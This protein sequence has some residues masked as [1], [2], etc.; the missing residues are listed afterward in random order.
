MARYKELLEQKRDL[1]RLI[2]E[3]RR[4]EAA[5]ALET[6]RNIVAEFGLTAE[7]VFGKRRKGS[8][9]P[10]TP[11]YRNPETGDTWSGRGRVPLWL[12]GQKR[13]PFLITE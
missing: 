2:E 10:A 12:A 11:K 4:G 9:V 7:D 6:V 1:E 5:A 8:A 3:A 13:E